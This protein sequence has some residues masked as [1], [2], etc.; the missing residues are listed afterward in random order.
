MRGCSFPA[1]KKMIR[2]TIIA[3]LGLSLRSTAL[4]FVIA[5]LAGE[6]I[7]YNGKPSHSQN[8]DALDDL[9][10]L[11]GCIFWRF[12]FEPKEGDLDRCSNAGP[13]GSR[14]SSR[15]MPRWPPSPQQGP[16]HM[17]NDSAREAGDVGNWGPNQRGHRA[18]TMNVERLTRSCIMAQINGQKRRASSLMCT[19]L[20]RQRVIHLDAKV[21][22]GAFDP[23]E[24]E[25]R[26]RA[27]AGLAIRGE[28]VRSAARSC[29]ALSRAGP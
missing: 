9:V 3:S 23:G 22:D 24:V 2:P 20:H 16:C 13:S 26:V 10:D 21:S 25:V 15:S 18:E 4:R 7:L 27:D 6:L 29:I 11:F 19:S 12:H 14:L 8:S 28:A 1:A 5:R 17:I